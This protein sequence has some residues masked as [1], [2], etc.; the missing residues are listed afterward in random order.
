MEGGRAGLV[1]SAGTPGRNQRN[2]LDN[3]PG[4][5]SSYAEIYER[6]LAISWSHDTARPAKLVLG[7]GHLSDFART[8][9]NK[10][11]P[12]ERTVQATR[13]TNRVLQHA[14]KF[15]VPYGS[16][17][18]TRWGSYKLSEVKAVEIE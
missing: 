7:D 11:R 13:R 2:S 8:F 18:F 4:Q 10:T 14:W 1:L 17:T 5:R 6:C 3:V 9:A 15:G 12:K 16:R